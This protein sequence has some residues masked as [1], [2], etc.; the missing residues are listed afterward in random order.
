M[1]LSPSSPCLDAI[2]LISE[3]EG[4]RP[5]GLLVIEKNL[6]VYTLYRRKIKLGPL[7]ISNYSL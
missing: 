3:G 5:G 1:Q 6:R 2:V 4:S 7:L